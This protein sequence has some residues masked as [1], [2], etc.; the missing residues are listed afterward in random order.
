MGPK[1][2]RIQTKS[3][4]KVKVKVKSC[5][6]FLCF[7]DRASWYDSG[8]MTNLMHNYVIQYVY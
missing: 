7:V 8:Q 3:K 6:F 1:P 2:S 5:P 4:V